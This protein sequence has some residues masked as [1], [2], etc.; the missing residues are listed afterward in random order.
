M[1]PAVMWSLA[2]SGNVRVVEAQSDEALDIN[3]E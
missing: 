3:R 2:L 1:L